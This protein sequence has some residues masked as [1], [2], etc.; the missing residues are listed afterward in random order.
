MR[1]MVRMI[2]LA[3]PIVVHF[4]RVRERER[5]KEREGGREKKRGR[6]GKWRKSAKDMGNSAKIAFF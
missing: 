2:W 1:A 4:Y 5:K 3:G 6:G